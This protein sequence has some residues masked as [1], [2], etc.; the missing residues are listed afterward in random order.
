MYSIP[1]HIK[2]KKQRAKSGL[3][4]QQAAD[5]CRMPRHRWSDLELG[6]RRPNDSE[7]QTVC[8]IFHI[9]KSFVVPGGVTRQL[10]D[11]GALLTPNRPPFFSHQDRATHIR[12][13]SLR[14]RHPYLTQKLL[15]LVQSR[16]DFQTC[17]H[18][19]HVLSCDSHLEALFL[20]HLQAVGARPA[21]VAPLLL[22]PLPHP[23]VSCSGE[24]LVGLR[25]RPCF[26]HCGTYYFFQVSFRLSR[27]VR[28]DVLE[29]YNGWKVLEFD[30]QGHRNTFD[31]HRD[32][33]LQLPVKRV[34][35]PE[36]AA[37]IQTQLAN[38][39]A[40]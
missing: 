1:F 4:Q 12:F 3:T 20:L 36:L 14:K 18:L 23:V 5:I 26:F 10:L 2:L 25:P 15:G 29:W 35:E 11:E 6:R 33:E 17:E 13:G 37:L 21:L 22:E 8:R 9:G 34:S 19:C 31:N 16:I 28:V 39:E 27:I 32:L 38:V 7:L 24:E 40:A 30:G